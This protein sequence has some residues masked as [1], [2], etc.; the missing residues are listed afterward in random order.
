MDIG[1]EPGAGAEESAGVYCGL[2]HHLLFAGHVGGSGF[3]FR[4]AQKIGA[5]TQAA[6]THY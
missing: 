5:M 1:K 6:F 2:V 4:L 3:L